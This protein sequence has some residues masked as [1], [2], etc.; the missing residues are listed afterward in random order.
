ME[1]VNLTLRKDLAQDLIISGVAMTSLEMVIQSVRPT[2]SFQRD[3]FSDEVKVQV[4]KKFY[5]DFQRLF[6]MAGYEEIIK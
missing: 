3:M 4:D 5:L 2:I 6:K 1:I